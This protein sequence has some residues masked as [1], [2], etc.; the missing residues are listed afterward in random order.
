MGYGG[1][2]I[3]LEARFASASGP[4]SRA[5]PRD[6][7]QEPGFQADSSGSRT[8]LLPDPSPEQPRTGTPLPGPARCRDQLPHRTLV[9]QAKRDIGLPPGRG[10]KLLA[11][12]AHEDMQV[13]FRPLG[14]GR[15]AAGPA[16][17]LR[18]GRRHPKGR[19]ERPPGISE[20]ALAGSWSARPDSNR[21]HPRWQRGALP[22]ELLAPGAAEISQRFRGRRG[23][24][25]AA[26]RG[27][28]DPGPQ[29]RVGGSRGRRTSKQLPAG[30]ESMRISPP[31]A[32][33]I[34]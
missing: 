9:E 18:R 5:G 21:R 29:V 11:G 8:G 23:W 30:E 13:L 3:P 27:P 19:K 12:T 20:E 14:A 33:A 16:L 34:W 17:L 6:N 4:Q 22:T 2:I 10:P 26:R 7:P 31:W 1:A 15:H 25:E 32:A 24:A 28:P